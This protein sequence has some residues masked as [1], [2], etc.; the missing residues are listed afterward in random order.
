MQTDEKKGRLLM[1]VLLTLAREEQARTKKWSHCTSPVKFP[2][3]TRSSK[4]SF[5][6][7]RS[8]HFSSIRDK[9]T[10]FFGPS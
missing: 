9:G 6:R 5:G 2:V 1:V 4:S 8:F 7:A 3:R 10:V